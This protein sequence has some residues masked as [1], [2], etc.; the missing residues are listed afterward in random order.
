MNEQNR[1]DNSQEQK[2][3]GNEKG[4]GMDEI[5]YEKKKGGELMKTYNLAELERR[6]ANLKDATKVQCQKGNYDTNEYMRGM[7]NGLKL[8]DG[9]MNDREPK[10]FKKN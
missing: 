9:I 1:K 2:T 3:Q 8:A 4:S 7:A 5:N 10:F 6:M